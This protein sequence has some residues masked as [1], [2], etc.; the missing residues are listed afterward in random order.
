M[1]SP[2]IKKVEFN[3]VDFNIDVKPTGKTKDVSS[4]GD[5]TQTQ[6]PTK[7][8]SHANDEVHI[9][10]F[11]RIELSAGGAVDMLSSESGMPA[12][13]TISRAANKLK[14]DGNVC[15]NG[16]KKLAQNIYNELKKQYA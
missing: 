3:K 9:S 13:N 12:Y 7:A 8:P 4:T 1:F 15:I 14:Y 6:A 2:I 16:T 5:A 11:S 10:E